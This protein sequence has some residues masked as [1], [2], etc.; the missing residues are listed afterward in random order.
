MNAIRRFFDKLEPKARENKYL[1]TTYEAFHTF[2]FVPKTVTTQGSHIRDGLDLKRVMIFVVIA[3]QLPML[4]GMWNI[5]HWHYAAHGLYT[6]YFDGIWPK[7]AFGLLQLLPTI[8]VSYVVGL[9]IE[10]LFA[11]ARGHEVEEGFLVTGMLIPLIMPPDIPLWM[12]AL[13]TAFAVIIVKE[14]FGGTGMNL[15]NV[16][17]SARV[18][19]F[20]AYPTYMSGDN[21]WIAWDTNFLHDLFGLGVHSGAD[22]VQTFTGATP[23]G[24]GANPKG[25][26]TAVGTLTGLH[27][28]TH[29]YSLWQM[30]FG[31]MPGSVGETSAIAILA[32]ALLLVITR[33]AD[34]R[35]MVSMILGLIFMSTFLNLIGHS[36][37]TQI[38]WYYHIFM[39]GFLFAM[40]FMATDPV[41]A[42]QTT[43]GKYIYGFLIGVIGML[44]RVI[45]PAYPEGWMMAILFMNVLAPLIDHLVIQSNMKKRL[46][47]G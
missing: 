28:I 25:I 29:Q 44:V 17:L 21:V 14:A 4:F 1:Y 22:I 31:V 36:P 6:G 37:F 47:R 18:F 11:A 26:E 10:F 35:I 45:N 41:T 42:A 7:F 30:I 9:G 23:L 12:V 34:W 46:A 39:G 15:L 3:L 33:I 27:A 5:G 2:F 40:A 16:A 24:L 19:I 43:K 8:V 32:G 20:F 13:A 38:P